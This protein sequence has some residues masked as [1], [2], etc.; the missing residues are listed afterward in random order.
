MLHDRSDFERNAMAGAD[1][2][3]P[4]NLAPKKDAQPARAAS[5]EAACLD[6]ANVEAGVGVVLRCRTIDPAGERHDPWPPEQVRRQRAGL[7][8]AGRVGLAGAR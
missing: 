5:C 2:R 6:A 8:R 3:C 1:I 7:P 4:E